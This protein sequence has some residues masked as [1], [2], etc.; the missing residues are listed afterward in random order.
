MNEFVYNKLLKSFEENP[1]VIVDSDNEHY[2]IIKDIKQYLKNSGADRL[3]RYYRNKIWIAP[4]EGIY[5]AEKLQNFMDEVIP[6]NLSG[7][8]WQKANYDTCDER[9]S[10]KFP[11]MHFYQVVVKGTVTLDYL[12]GHEQVK[13][14]IDIQSEMLT[15]VVA[16]P[17]KLIIPQSHTPL[18]E[19]HGLLDR[20]LPSEYFIWNDLFQQYLENKSKIKGDKK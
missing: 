9:G 8:L 5:E 14:E 15:E 16:F 19:E 13:E 6:Y 11:V 1:A 4:K 10:F 7:E 2:S 18:I 17:D 20:Y 12:I 3:N